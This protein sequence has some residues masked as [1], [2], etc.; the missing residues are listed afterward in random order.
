MT[1]RR[2]PT[3][4]W[5]RFEARK[6]DCWKDLT[7]LGLLLGK[8]HRAYECDR[9]VRTK[10]DHCRAGAASTQWFCR[11]KPLAEPAIRG[12]G[13]RAIQIVPG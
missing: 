1:R 3:Q 11:M 9:I 4:V 2:G 10:Q 7:G 6:K 13:A 12:R 5:T 8:D